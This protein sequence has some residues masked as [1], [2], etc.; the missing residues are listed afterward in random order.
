MAVRDSKESN[1]ATKQ[2]N[3]AR[4]MPA[5]LPQGR[6]PQSYGAPCSGASTRRETQLVAS[7]SRT[8]RHTSVKF[9]VVWRAV[10]EGGNLKA[11]KTAGLPRGRK[12][13]GHANPSSSGQ[14]FHIWGG[15]STRHET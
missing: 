14:G 11:M 1:V 3:L 13:E 15:L 7:T 12:P 5:G 8:A 9:T 10:P 2:C 6:N 4:F